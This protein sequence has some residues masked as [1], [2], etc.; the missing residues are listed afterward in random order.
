[1]LEEGRREG[2]GGGREE[3]KRGER[4]EGGGRGGGRRKGRK[5]GKEGGEE[6]GSKRE[7]CSVRAMYMQSQMGTGHVHL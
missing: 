6:G 5:E 2:V 7:L 1:M 3:G 4:K